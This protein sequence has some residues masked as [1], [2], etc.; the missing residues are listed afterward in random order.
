MP[1]PQIIESKTIV[2]DFA[3]LNDYG[4]LIVTDKEGQ[5]YKVAKK[6]EHLHSLFTED[7]AITLHFAKY[8]DKRYVADASIPELPPP[9]KPK[10]PDDYPD[11]EVTSTA[12]AVK[13][14]ADV[15][16]DKY[17]PKEVK[18]DTGKNG[19][20]SFPDERTRDIH[21]QVALKCATELITHGIIGKGEMKTMAIAMTDFLDTG[22]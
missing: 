1:Q 2:V 22:K 16:T 6:R 9:T 17:I 8:M 11:K 19:A 15:V 3:N 12:T 20:F 14:T 7:R 13:S 21:R 4:D 18:R 5:D 10:T